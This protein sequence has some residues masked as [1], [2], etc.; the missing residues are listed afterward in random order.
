MRSCIGRTK[1]LGSWEIDDFF[2]SSLN[3]FN[4]KRVLVDGHNEQ[5]PPGRQE[6]M[7][8]QEEKTECNLE[9]TQKLA[10]R[11]T[12][13]SCSELSH[14]YNTTARGELTT[15]KQTESTKNLSLAPCSPPW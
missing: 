7:K 1:S 9:L 13:N 6:G 8:A 10:A 12:R 11:P 3:S 4:I 14:C 2:S 5:Q 15:E